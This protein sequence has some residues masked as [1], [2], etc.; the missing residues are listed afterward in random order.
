MISPDNICHLDEEKKDEERRI[1]FSWTTKW[2][3]CMF[4]CDVV[5]FPR[6]GSSREDRVMVQLSRKRW[7]DTI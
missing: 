5:R 7:F 2:H 1:F 4:A 3:K 6:L